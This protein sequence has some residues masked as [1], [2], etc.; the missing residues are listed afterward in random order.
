MRRI[1]GRSIAVLLLGAIVL[2]GCGQK[3]ITVEIPVLMEPVA[4]NASFRPVEVG[5]IGEVQ[6]LYGTVVPQEYCAFYDTNVMIEDIAVE[7]GDYVRKGDVIAYAD[8]HRARTELED[9]KRQAEYMEQTYELNMKINQLRIVQNSAAYD[10][11]IEAVRGTVSG[12]DVVDERLDSVSGGDGEAFKEHNK[13][14]ENL[15]QEKDAAVKVALENLYYDEILHGYR[16]QNLKKEIEEK[17]KVISKG[18]L[19]APHSGYVVYVKNLNMGTEAAAYENIVVVADLEETYIELE[20]MTAGQ[21]A[22]KKYKDYEIK[23][24]KIDGEGFNVTE[25]SYGTEAE[26]FAKASGKYPNVR[27]VCDEKK[28]LILGE[29]YPILYREHDASGEAIIGWDSLEG[30]EGAYFVYVKGE[31]GEKEKRPVII[32]ETDQYHVQVLDG[33]AVGEMVYYES[34]ALMPADYTEYTVTLSDYSI[35]NMSESFRAADAPVVWYDAEYTGTIQELAVKAGDWVE[36]GDLLYEMRSDAGKAALADALNEINRENKVYEE[37]MRRLEESLAVEGDETAAKILKFRQELEQVTHT[38]RLRQLEEAYAAIKQNNDG[39]G[40][41][42]VYAKES[43]TVNR[44]PVSEY[45]GKTKDIYVSQGTPILSIG[46]ETE[47]KLLVEMAE[48]KD[49][50]GNITVRSYPDNIARVG[51][52]VTISV[53]ENE[54]FEGV[55]VGWN[56][57]EGVN[58]KKN[59]ITVTEDGVKISFCTSSGYSKPSFYV[60]MDDESIYQRIGQGLTGGRVV[61][62]YV[63]MEGVTVVPSELVKEETNSQNPNKTNYYVWRIV[64]NELVKQ[65]VLINKEYS[66]AYSTLIL[67]GVEEG[68]VL[69]WER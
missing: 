30:E 34:E 42:R 66:D 32:G 62:S 5:A 10:A 9:T 60:E 52:K 59:Y 53:G 64:G 56:A 41:V 63:E 68:D 18:I 38:Y 65:Y 6:V 26:V 61:F 13:L 37:T 55:C 15:Y 49:S 69:A 48:I 12:N 16:M 50:K 58:L 19:R 29:T 51:E 14:L 24:I 39:N 2:G 17:Q 45:D 47:D 3:Q 4:T 57:H 7:V 44:V 20:D 28:E 21:Y 67:S 11:Q 25:L 33:L 8:I 22:Y 31:D 1:D 46:E 27:L 35:D 43:G 23:E 40:I 54:V 36:K